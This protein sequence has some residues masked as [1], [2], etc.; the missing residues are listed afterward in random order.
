MTGE[1][2]RV[3]QLV[4]LRVRKAPEVAPNPDGGRAHGLRGGYGCGLLP[5]SASC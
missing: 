4:R 1:R 3:G 2:F 5:G